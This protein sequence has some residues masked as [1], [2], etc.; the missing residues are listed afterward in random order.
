MLAAVD[1]DDEARFPAGEIDHIGRDRKL[2]GE[3]RTGMREEALQ[4]PFL[5]FGF[6]AQRA[7]KAGQLFLDAAFHDHLSS[8]RALR[9]THP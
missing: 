1:L 7:R 9:A 6:V 8:T 5:R 3:L 2:A 4:R